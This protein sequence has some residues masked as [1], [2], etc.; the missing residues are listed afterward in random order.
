MR[1][2]EGRLGRVFIL[3]LEDG[4]VV[5]ECIERFAAEQ[6]VSH[7]QVVLL[8]GIGGG[9]VVVGPR[10]SDAMPPEPM[11]LPVDGTHEVA[12]VGVLAPGD[13]GRPAL[14][15]HGALGRSGQ[16][17]TGCLRE[18]VRTWVVLEAVLY[19]IVGA[20]ATRCMDPATGFPLLQAGQGPRDED[21][22]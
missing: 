18:G 20:Q 10:D 8:G 4:D 6:G 19:E 3:R 5:P 17:L 15:I 13:S 9:Q 12:A 2:T 7:G 11:L 22:H 1:S 14:H 21:E 16:T